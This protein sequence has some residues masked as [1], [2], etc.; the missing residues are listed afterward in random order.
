[1]MGSQILHSKEKKLGAFSNTSLQHHQIQ[2]G[3]CTL[4]VVQDLCNSTYCNSNKLAGLLHVSWWLWFVLFCTNNTEEAVVFT[5]IL[6]CLHR[7]MAHRPLSQLA[8]QL[9]AQVMTPLLRTCAAQLR[10][11]MCCHHPHSHIHTHA[12]THVSCTEPL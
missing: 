1:M 9:T 7:Y 10:Q 8:N 12:H 2:Q 11:T 5:A 3:S 4:A 6:C